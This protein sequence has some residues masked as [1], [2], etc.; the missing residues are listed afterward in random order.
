MN[1]DFH[2]IL[3]PMKMIEISFFQENL[4]TPSEVEADG[5]ENSQTEMLTPINSIPTIP[6][7]GPTSSSKLAPADNLSRY[8]SIVTYRY[9]YLN[10][11]YSSYF[12]FRLIVPIYTVCDE[13]V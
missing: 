4:E 13:K 1:L 10:T 12:I 3:N 7:M 5:K 2:Q 9:R 8:L 6:Q 11:S